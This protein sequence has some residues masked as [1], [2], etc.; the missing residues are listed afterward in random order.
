MQTVTRLD[1]A[2]YRRTPWKNG[3]GVTIDIADAYAPGATPGSWN[4]MLWRLGRTQIVEPGPFSDLSGYDRILTV[5]GGR[6]LVLE[7]AG[8]EALDVREPFQPVRFRG[9][10]RI[11]SRL[12]QGPVAVLNLI[13]DREHEIDVVVLGAAQTRPLKAA[14]NIVY[15]IEKSAVTIGDESYTL[16]ADEALRIDGAG[17]AVTVQG[18]R[19]ALASISSRS[20]P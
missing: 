5:T 16:T 6:G 20:A 15:A 13:A 11:V 3:G 17:G 14:L 4:G 7:V 9:E 2:S 1:P 12:E 10:D 8:G 19:A 18:G